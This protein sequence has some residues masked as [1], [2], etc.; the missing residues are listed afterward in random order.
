MRYALVRVQTDAT[1]M[2]LNAFAHAARLHPELVRRFVALGLL[3][4]EQDS[5]GTLWFSPAQIVEAARIQ[6]LRA[7]LNLNYAA[8]G[9]VIELLD[10]L[11]ELEAAARS[12][13]RRG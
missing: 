8:V 12:R 11:A 5:A 4:P 10:R 2:D 9:V 3:D 6:R 1:R 7:G 13:H